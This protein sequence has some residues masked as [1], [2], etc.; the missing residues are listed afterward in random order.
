MAFAIITGG[1]LQV[2]MNNNVSMRLCAGV[3]VDKLKRESDIMCEA[4][5]YYKY[6]ISIC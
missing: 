2:S 3:D 5:A 6:T 1:I 4:V